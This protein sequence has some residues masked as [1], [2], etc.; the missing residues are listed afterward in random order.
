MPSI[1]A[2]WTLQQPNQT[3]GMVGLIPAH[4]GCP[5][6]GCPYHFLPSIL[7]SKSPFN[8]SCTQGRSN[9]C[10][11]KSLHNVHCFHWTLLMNT[12][13]LYCNASLRILK[14]I[15]F[16]LGLHHYSWSLSSRNGTLKTVTRLYGIQRIM[17]VQFHLITAPLALHLS[18]PTIQLPD[19]DSLWLPHF[20]EYWLKRGICW[21]GSEPW[22]L[23][24]NS[25][26]YRAVYYIVYLVNFVGP[27][28]ESKR[29][30]SV[31]MWGIKR[32]ADG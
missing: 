15:W 4:P 26:Y 11:P 28:P 3:A 8:V 6:H 7:C 5:Y 9:G 14:I 18:P 21:G 30:G 22:I 2:F 13:F 19:L 12:V 29:L 32:E 24:R 16:P 17:H 27:G 10:Y 20:E 1:V 25:A 23:G 31:W